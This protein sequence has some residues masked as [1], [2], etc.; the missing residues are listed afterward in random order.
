[1]HTHFGPN[2]VAAARA[3][4]GTDLS[5]VA[6]LHGF[7]L[8]AVPRAEGWAGYRRAL[9]DATVVVH[10]RFAAELV[11]EGMGRPPTVVTYRPP[12]RSVARA[13]AWPHPLRLL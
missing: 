11:A 4:R 10:S 3:L 1:V 13:D 2:A 6:D 12:P 8:T 9:G 7:D 5:L